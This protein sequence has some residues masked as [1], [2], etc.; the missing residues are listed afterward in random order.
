MHKGT[1]GIGIEGIT[2]KKEQGS[3]SVKSKDFGLIGFN[4]VT[5]S[6]NL[7]VY[8]SFFARQSKVRTSVNH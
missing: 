1:H 6:A 5:V 2:P 8:T 4:D 7:K 3:L